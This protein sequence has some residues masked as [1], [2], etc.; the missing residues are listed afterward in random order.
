VRVVV[1]SD[2]IKKAT[3]TNHGNKKGDTAAGS[4]DIA[5][6]KAIRSDIADEMTSY[7]VK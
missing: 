2:S 7:G 5:A 6:A 1:S 3:A 4:A